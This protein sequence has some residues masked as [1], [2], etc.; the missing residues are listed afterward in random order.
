MPD[1]LVRDLDKSVVD[2]LKKK[3]AQ[4]GRS[5]QAEVKNI[6]SEAAA[7]A[8]MRSELEVMQEIKES[9]RGFKQSDSAELIRE[10]RAR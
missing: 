7:V 9:L 3:A 4:H 8:D 6:L 10:D 1:V 2:K 5:L